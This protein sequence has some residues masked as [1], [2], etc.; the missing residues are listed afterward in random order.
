[1]GNTNTAR[2]KEIQ[3]INNQ[4]VQ[5][6]SEVC[7]A[8]CS[9]VQNGDTSIINNSTVQGTVKA[10]TQLCTVDASCVMKQQLADNINDTLKSIAQQTQ[11][12]NSS[13]LS[14]FADTHNRSS[15]TIEQSITNSVTQLLNS[16]CTAT[17][18][19][20]Q[21]GD[22]FIFSNSDVLSGGI[23]AFS[24]VGNATASCTMNNISKIKL[25]NN[26]LAKISQNQ[27]TESTLLAIIAVIVA[28]IVIVAILM[29]LFFGGLILFGGV[30][31]VKTVTAKPTTAP[32]DTD[33]KSTSSTSK[34]SGGTTILSTGG[35]KASSDTEAGSKAGEATT[36]GT[37]AGEAAT[38]GGEAA[39]AGEVL[40][41]LLL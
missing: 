18:S 25:Y 29:F 31:A 34:T 6:S 10:F 14:I 33:D 37:E 16:S 2:A 21:N 7:K 27:K 3:T 11:S 23:I 36:E 35:S 5:E 24:Q 30:E 8:T 13:I 9:N 20:I 15:S 38:A 19:N 32:A 26:E 1:M 39:E 40:P 22:M 28:A 17:S 41:F 12:L 4:I